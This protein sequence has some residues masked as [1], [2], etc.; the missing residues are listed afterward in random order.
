MVV[1]VVFFLFLLVTLFSGCGRLTQSSEEIK[2]KG[3]TGTVT[4][5]T[6]RY[7]P[8]LECLGKLIKESGQAFNQVKASVGEIIDKTGK[9]EGVGGNVLT[10]SASEMALI[11][12]S[13]TKAIHLVGSTDKSVLQYNLVKRNP[14]QTQLSLLGVGNLGSVLPS[15][16][17][18]TGSISEYNSDMRT[19]NLSFNFFRKFLD[20]NF[21]ATDRVINIAM[22]LRVVGSSSGHILTNE[23]GEM[24]ALSL[25]NTVITRNFNGSIFRILSDAGGGANLAV[26]IADPVHFAIREIIEKGVLMLVGQLYDVSWE[27][28]DAVIPLETDVAGSLAQ[29]MNQKDRLYIQQILEIIPTH[30]ATKW[31]NMDTQFQMVITKTYHKRNNIACRNY[32][33]TVIKNNYKKRAKMTAC[34]Q[35]DGVWKDI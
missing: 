7:T 21:S 4:Q 9:V 10:Q 6:T 12:L 25:Q 16:F 23:K 14:T 2:L 11:A 27:Q 30:E 17:F 5:N 8:S 1:K 22:D 26:K 35:A 19:R 29:Y 20:T 13:R 32:H 31:T 15:H 28:C 24:L 33:I 34:R 3:T 18:I